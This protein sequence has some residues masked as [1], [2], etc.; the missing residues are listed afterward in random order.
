MIPKPILVTGSHRSGSTWIGKVIASAP[1]TLYVHEPFNIGIKR[2]NSS[3][4]YWNECITDKTDY[5]KQKEVLQYL[6]YFYAL[7]SEYLIEEI[8]KIKSYAL[9]KDC[10]WICKQRIINRTVLKDPIA[11]FSTEWIYQ[12]TNC[13]VIVSIRHPAA[14]IASLMVKNWSFD[15]NNF[16]KQK[17]LME[18]Y[19]A[20]YHTTIEEYAKHP[21]D[22]IDQGILLW[23]TIYS[24]VYLY[25]KKYEEK[26]LFYK[27]EDISL[28]PYETFETIF[29]RI[30]LNYSEE[31]KNY[32]KNTTEK[33]DES[34]FARNSKKNISTWKSRLTQEQ[35]ERIKKGTETV[36]KKFY[37]E[38]EWL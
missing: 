33:E 17:I 36:W 14:F 18:T 8:K 38:E 21:P 2:N 19:L 11:I 32:I 31:V 6:K 10:Y 16:L 20:E 23:N 3:L 26:W 30:N 37:T 7:P 5:K 25:K 13:D 22:I 9:A 24:T 27:H 29:K 12:K 15:F 34:E 35:I 4:Q 1:N 28:N